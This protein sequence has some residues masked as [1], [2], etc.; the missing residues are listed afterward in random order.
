VERLLPPRGA[1]TFVVGP[2]PVAPAF[3]SRAAA[4]HGHQNQKRPAGERRVPRTAITHET[5]DEHHRCGEGPMSPA[6]CHHR[7]DVLHGRGWTL[8]L[9]DTPAL[10]R[11]V[12]AD[13]EELASGPPAADRNP[14]P[15][16][17]DRRR[18][19]SERRARGRGSSG[20]GAAR[21]SKRV[22]PEFAR[23]AGCCTTPRSIHGWA[24]TSGQPARSGLC[25]I[26]LERRRPPGRVAALSSASRYAT[27]RH[28]V[29]RPSKRRFHGD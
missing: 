15:I 17:S 5:A 19:G 28:G 24:V 2:H 29:A 21:S 6:C 22:E 13:G 25:L 27:V 1:S 7:L 23:S 12:V 20:P 10:I 26:D 14:V 18:T 11:E 16:R 4:A 9:Q 3:Q 8:V